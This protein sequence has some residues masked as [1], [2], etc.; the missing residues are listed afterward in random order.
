MTTQQTIRRKWRWLRQVG[1]VLGIKVTL[2]LI[3]VAVFFG[4]GAGNPFLRRLAIKRINSI[5]GGQAELGSLSIQWL[6]MRA[7]IK[8]FVIRGKEPVGTEPLFSAEEIQAGLKIDSFWGRKVSLSE[9]VVLQP[10]I[11]IRAEKDGTTNVPAVPRVSTASSRP[12]RETLLDLRIRHFSLTDGWVLYNDVKT[13]LA[14]EGND[15][16][17]NFDAGG[18]MTKPSGCWVNWTE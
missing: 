1:W 17:L 7:T 15:L 10:H 16:Q 2:L 13:P 4:S 8:G 12:L 18:S 14:L 9:I 11:H 6:S 3:A 5:T